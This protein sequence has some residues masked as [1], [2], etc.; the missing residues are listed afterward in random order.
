ML[1]GLISQTP[2]TEHCFAATTAFPDYSSLDYGP[3]IGKSPLPTFL[4]N[5]I[6]E[7]LLKKFFFLSDNPSYGLTI[8]QG[9]DAA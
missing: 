8:S 3:F 7:E 1:C 2:W 5:I 6:F 9:Y 4:P